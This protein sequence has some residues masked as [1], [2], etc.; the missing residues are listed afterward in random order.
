MQ[1]WVHLALWK[2]SG[3]EKECTALQLQRKPARLLRLEAWAPPHL[4]RVCDRWWWGHGV[5]CSSWYKQAYPSVSHLSCRPT[6]HRIPNPCAVLQVGGFTV[7]NTQL[8]PWYPAFQIYLNL[9]HIQGCW[10]KANLQCS[11]TGRSRSG[12]NPVRAA[13]DPWLTY[14]KYTNHVHTA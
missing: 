10:A 4:P 9:G 3:Q 14:I 11:Q 7:Y 8:W 5:C 6:L 2:D 13:V 12:R 1:Q